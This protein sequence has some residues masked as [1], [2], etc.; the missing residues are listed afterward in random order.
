MSDVL[1]VHGAMHGGWC[2]RPVEELLRARG[3]RCHA[4]TLTGCGDRAHLLTPDVGVHTHVQDIL[5]SLEMEDMHGATLVLHSYAGI[6]AGPVAERAGSRV[7]RVVAIGAFLA[8]P[9]E[10]LLDVE[11]P[12]V[13]DR[14][15]ALIA[16]EGDGVRVPATDAFLDQWA[17]PPAL[18]A[19]VGA[20]LTD[21]PARCVDQPVRYDPSALAVHERHYIA[22]TAPPLASL[23][24]SAARARAQGWR[25]HSIATGHDAMLADPRGTADLIHRIAR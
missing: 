1:L 13:A 6:L 4:P 5:A 7:R 9:G 18:R 22:H 20:R 15:R 23:A 21:F 3:H 17:V 2:W 10:S 11:P 14:Y 25:M 8:D 12:E 16:D 19:S 24:A